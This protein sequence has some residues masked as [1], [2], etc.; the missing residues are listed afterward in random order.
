MTKY[1]VIDIGCIE[2]GEATE[3]VGVYSTH[4][5]AQRALVARAGNEHGGYFADGQR[6]VEIFAIEVES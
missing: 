2:C 4:V 6:R 5:A 3:V 1:L